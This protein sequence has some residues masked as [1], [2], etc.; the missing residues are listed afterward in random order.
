MTNLIKVDL[1]RALQPDNVVRSQMARTTHLLPLQM[2]R[3]ARKKRAGRSVG[4]TMIGGLAIW[5]RKASQA[6][7]RG[8]RFTLEAQVCL[9]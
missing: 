5:T 3:V 1:P 9:T 7:T 6:K 4:P 2:A 8:I